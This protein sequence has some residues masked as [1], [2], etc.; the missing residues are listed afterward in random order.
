MADP[1]VQQARERARRHIDRQGI[2]PLNRTDDAIALDVLFLA[3]RVA[4]LETA[5]RKW[6]ATFPAHRAEC[7]FLTYSGCTC[8][9]DEARR[10][11][12]AVLAGSGTEPAQEQPA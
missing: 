6:E 1:R 7:L 11:T 12:A 9:L 2:W 8:G 5:L 4:E 10:L 3:D